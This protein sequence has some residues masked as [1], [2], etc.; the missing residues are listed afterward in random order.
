MTI[1]FHCHLDLYRDP[2]AVAEEANKRRVAVLSVTTTPSAFQ[3]TSALA[4]GLP[5]I[6]TALGIHPE[7]AAEREHELPLFD[8]LLTRTRFVGEV[9]LDGQDRFA[10]SR[11][12]QERVFDHVL[13]RCARSGGRIISIHS[14]QAVGRVIQ[15]ITRSGPIG[16]PV[17]HWFTGS[18]KQADAALEAGCWFSV[19]AAMLRSERGR[20]LVAQLPIERVVTETDGPFTKAGDQVAHPWQAQ[21]AAI[22]L[23]RLWQQS[24]DGTTAQLRANLSALLDSIEPAA[25]FDG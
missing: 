18:L 16:A 7:L 9:G 12:A 10:A 20:I 15:L 5:F 22:E 23:G 19:G 8:K 3:G 1:D 21:E 2:R 11:A 4:D 24:A 17:L 6:R 13:D 25:T 14:R